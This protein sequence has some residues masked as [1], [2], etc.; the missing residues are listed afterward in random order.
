MARARPLIAGGAPL[1]AGLVR[2]LALT[3]RV[4]VSGAER[5][6]PWWRADRPLIYA[7]WHGHILMLPW[8]NEWL[9]RTAGARSVTVL[10][11]RSR[12]GELV[13]RYVGRFGFAVVRGSSSRGG[14]GALRELH[15]VLRGGGDVAITPDG[16]RGPRGQIQPGVVTLAAWSGAPLV[17]PPQDV[18]RIP[19]AAAVRARRARRRR[20]ADR[21]A[22]RRSP[23]HHQGPRTGA[24]RSDRRGGSARVPVTYLLYTMAMRA[25]LLGYLPVALWRRLAHGVPLHLRAR[26][27]RGPAPRDGRPTAWVHAVSV[28]EA[29]AAGTLLEGL[30]RVCPELPLVVT[31]VTETGARVVRE[32]F[33]TLATHRFFPVDLPGPARR[34]VAAINPAFFIGMET[35]LWPNILRALARR[36]VPTMVANGRLSD[37]SFRRYRLAGRLLRPLL[38]DVRVFAM[39]S[40]EDARRI[41]ALGA[42]P[43]RVFVTGNLKNEP[44]AEPTGSVELWCR[45][46]GLGSG[47]RVWIAGSTHRG[48]EEG[49]LR[50]HRAARCDDPTLA[51]ILAPR[52]PERVP[53]V[54]GLV[55]AR[56]WRAV[57]RTELPG[58]LE[59]PA[60]PPPVIVLDTVGELAQLYAVADVVFTGGSLVPTGGHNMLEPALRR[61]PVLFGP[62]TA[63]FREAAALLVASGG[64]I[65]VH[66]AGELTEQLRRLLADAALRAKLGAAAAE[67]VASQHGSVKATLDLVDR[68]LRPAER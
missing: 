67:A 26:L 10:A 23:A 37:R 66:D 4:R 6:V 62:H 52:H 9:R 34:A 50:A 55:A 36:G 7:V 17:P 59:A 35:E 32:R 20:T 61:K 65:V 60:V 12:D 57:R 58:S 19:G 28:G 2:A 24:G 3:M 47:Q 44:L 46:L 48:E 33:A 8:A 53:E 56:G 5:L 15:G 40:E 29:V 27:G 42:R 13:S 25:L 63:N 1:L 38:N 49:V 18:G 11:S 43:E 54:L 51:L 30:R 16:P 21:G 22:R 14:R 39:Q 64:G 41:I 45:L 68:F 31:T